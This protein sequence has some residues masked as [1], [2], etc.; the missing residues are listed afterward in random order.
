[1]AHNE[2][3]KTLDSISKQLEIEDEHQKSLVPPNV[4]LITK[5]RKYKGKKAFLWQTSQERYV[6]VPLKT[7][8][9]GK[10]LPRSRRLRAMGTRI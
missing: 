9:L 10:V 2:N 1:M 4:A 8:D 3:I 5:G 6:N 7:P